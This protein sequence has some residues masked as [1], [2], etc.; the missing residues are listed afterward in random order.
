MT[1]ILH[2]AYL[3]SFSMRQI[4]PPTHFSASSVIAAS[5]LS[6]WSQLSRTRSF[7]S[8]L[9]TSIEDDSTFGD[10]PDPSCSLTVIHT[11]PPSIIVDPFQL[12]QLEGDGALGYSHFFSGEI[13]LELPLSRLGHGN[14]SVLV[15]T[16]ADWQGLLEVPIHG[17]YLPA[18]TLEEEKEEPSLK[19]ASRRI[20]LTAPQVGW[21]CMPN[22]TSGTLRRWARASH[23]PVT[24]V[25]ILLPP[26]RPCARMAPGLRLCELHPTHSDTARGTTLASAL[27]RGRDGAGGL[28]DGWMGR[29]EGMAGSA[30]KEED[31]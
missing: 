20:Q 14:D 6:S 4:H 31:K 24:H 1:P 19:D 25:L 3:S 8:K 16:L 7:H 27:R 11:F 17:R 13:E 2:D 30:G 23:R 9:T 10:A 29:A 26:R 12:A 5:Y 15:V 28:G 22:A 21:A 18:L